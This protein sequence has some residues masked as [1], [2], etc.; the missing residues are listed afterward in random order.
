M[1]RREETSELVQVWQEA[2]EAGDDPIRALGELGAAVLAGTSTLQKSFSF[3]TVAA[4]E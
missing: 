4:P 1:S 3:T 2:R